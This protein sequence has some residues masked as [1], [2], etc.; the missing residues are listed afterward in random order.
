MMVKIKHKNLLN[1]FLILLLCLFASCNT[2]EEKLKISEALQMYLDEIETFDEENSYLSTEVIFHKKRKIRVIQ[3]VNAYNNENYFD[4]KE[5]VFKAFFKNKTFYTD[6]DSLVK[7]KLN[8]LNDLK[9]K[10]IKTGVDST[11]LPLPNS[12]PYISIHYDLVDNKVDKIYIY[13]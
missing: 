1:R 3:I 6:N 9:W 12:F 13:R 7:G 11:Y 5:Y 10:L 2:K 4:N 8:I